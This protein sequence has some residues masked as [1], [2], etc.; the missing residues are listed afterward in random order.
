MSLLDIGK[1]YYNAND[2]TATYSKIDN[3]IDFA[4]EMGTM[5]QE[6]ADFYRGQLFENGGSGLN[7][8]E[9]ERITT[10]AQEGVLAYQDLTNEIDNNKAA[11]ENSISAIF[12][13]ATSLEDLNNKQLQVNATLGESSYSQETYANGLMV[14]AAKY[15]HCTEEIQKYKAALAS[16]IGVE[17]AQEVLETSIKIGEEAESYGLVAVQVE[18]VADAFRDMADAGVEGMEALQDDDEAV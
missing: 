15:D 2:N 8:D 3:Q 12:N 13:S 1:S 6:D 14:L 16:G 5:T 11:I 17:E 7:A 18:T 4:Q 10:A 9:I